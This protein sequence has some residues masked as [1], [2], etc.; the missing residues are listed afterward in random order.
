MKKIILSAALIVGAMSVKAQSYIGYLTDNYSGVN[1]VIANPANIAD[2]R[3]KT[4]INLIGVSAFFSN[5]Y[6]GLKVTDAFNDDYDFDLDAK[7]T[8]FIG[9]SP[10]FTFSVGMGRARTFF[11]V[12]EIN[13][14]SINQID[15]DFDENDDFNLNEGDFYINGNAWAELGFTYARVLMDKE[16]H[17]LKGG[18]SLKYL[19]GVGNTYTTGKNVTINY[20]ADGTDLGG[21]ITTGNILLMVVM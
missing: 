13:G 1:S 4:D 21:G 12:H 10:N 9:S 11:N 20:D 17:F 2:S 3:F 18:L 8:L 15:N 14:E 7:K 16:Q 19:Q 6:Y 5:D